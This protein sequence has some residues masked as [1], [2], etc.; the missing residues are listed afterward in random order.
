MLASNTAENK[1]KP[2]DDARYCVQMPRGS[3]PKD[4]KWHFDDDKC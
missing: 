1:A 4:S 2:E 3:N